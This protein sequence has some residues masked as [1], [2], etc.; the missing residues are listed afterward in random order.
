M[1]NNR[2]RAY[3]S[4]ALGTTALLASQSDA[5][6]IINVN[7]STFNTGLSNIGTISRTGTGVPYSNSSIQVTGSFLMTDKMSS[8]FRRGNDANPATFV[9]ASASSVNY[10]FN[11]YG[12]SSAQSNAI[13]NSSDNWFYFKGPTNQSQQ[14]WLQFKFG[15]LGDG[16]GFSIVK[17]VY[18][19][20]PGQLTNALAAST[21]VPEP[22]A[23]ALLSLGASGLLV[24]R[25]RKT[26]A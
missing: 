24:R 4:T 2:L 8:T 26:A 14:V 3:S 1:K 16:S 7:S 19:D 12:G 11:N 17:A 15:G 18:P 22:S 13:L 23:L 9:P 6:T 10:A 5:A 25:R 21:A 20:S